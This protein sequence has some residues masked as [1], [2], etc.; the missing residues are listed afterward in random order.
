MV[1][2]PIPRAEYRVARPWHFQK[3]DLS[4]VEGRAATLSTQLL[5]RSVV[6]TFPLRPSQKCA[7][8]GV[9]K[10]THWD[11]EIKTMKGGPDPTDDFPEDVL[12]KVV[13]LYN[14]LEE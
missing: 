13:E 9:P 7:K 2:I 10:V 12:E 4:V 3:P 8:N 5:D 14:A 1:L 6:L 11:K